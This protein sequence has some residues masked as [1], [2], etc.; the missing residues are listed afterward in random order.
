MTGQFAAFDEDTDGVTVSIARTL[1]DLVQAIAMRGIVF[2]GEQECP[3]E[4]ELDGN[5]I[6]GA[7][8]LIARIGREPVGALRIRWFSEFAKIERVCVRRGYRKHGVAEKLWWFGGK[9][10]A[11]KGYRTVLGHVEP[12]LYDYWNRTVGARE[13]VDRDPLVFSDRRYIEVLV[14]LER[15]NDALSLDSPALVLLRP[16]GD[17]DVE[18]V[19]DRSADRVSETGAP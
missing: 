18:G 4:E 3:F 7:T 2:M 10:A 15:P 8:H 13:R 9:M 1:D 16:E 14:D 5:D 12:R 17:W 6:S 19:L 11:R